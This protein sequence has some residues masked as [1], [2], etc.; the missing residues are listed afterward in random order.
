LF[1][2]VLV[3]LY[4]FDDGPPKGYLTFGGVYLFFIDLPRYFRA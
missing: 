1:A 4:F 2:S 3:K